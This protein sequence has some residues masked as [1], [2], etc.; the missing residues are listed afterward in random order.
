MARNVF[1]WTVLILW[2]AGCGA[3]I[4]VA[5]DL[6]GDTSLSDSNLPADTDDSDSITDTTTMTDSDPTC[7]VLP[8][9]VTVLSDS[10]AEAFVHFGEGD[11]AWTT[12]DGQPMSSAWQIDTR[13]IT[14]TSTGTQLYHLIH[15][16]IAVGDHMMAELRARC[17]SAK[18][19]QCRLGMLIETTESPWTS[20]VSYFFE[21]GPEWQLYQIPIFAN[22][23]Y[24]AGTA[25]L[26][27]RLGYEDQSI[28]IL[29]MRLVNYGVLNGENHLECLPAMIAPP[30]AP[31]LLVDVPREATVDILYDYFVEVTGLSPSTVTALELPAWLSYDA[32]QNRI[33]GIPTYDDIGI[34]SKI[35]L[36]I[37]SGDQ[38]SKEES[39][40]QVSVD[41]ALIGHWPLD[42]TDGVVATDVSG[43]GRNGEVVGDPVWLPKDGRKNGAL[44]CD[45]STGSI[46]YVL[47]PS[48]PVTDT[49]QAGPHTLAA[50][51]RVE[52][53][54]AG[55]VESDN[56]FGYGILI[57]AGAHTGLW[58]DSGQHFRASYA[59]E[60]KSYS[61]IGPA[62]PPGE[63]HHIA[64]TFDPD[65][66]NYLLY[67]DGKVVASELLSG[68]DVYRDYGAEQWRIGVAAPDASSAVWGGD[69]SMDDVR[70][71]SKVLNLHE[72]GSLADIWEY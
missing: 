15:S 33:S 42:E 40:V 44:G 46:D 70:I 14:H 10:D 71:Y 62:T 64:V 52:S 9:A 8:E 41:A 38:T 57:K 19:G 68:V 31:S 26:T 13:Q 4:V 65:N 21:P 43:N 1:I 72:I 20:I 12:V 45:S 54:P 30:D 23:A 25:R 37:R 7:P 67:L 48:D 24:A 49:V 36:E 34:P 32:G 55:A 27:F 28:N 47:L 6:M 2:T 17:R 51:V 63:Y 39:D 5:D 22:T 16:D 11:I 58:Y 69:L 35:A 29:P 18:S 59:F 60:G 66:G 3:D 53:I 61:L 50:W 56:D